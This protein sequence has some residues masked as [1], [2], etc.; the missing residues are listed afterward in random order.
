MLGNPEK[1]RSGK[2]REYS[3]WII[4]CT[5]GTTQQGRYIRLSINAAISTRELTPAVANKLASGRCLIGI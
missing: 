2:R 4:D 3:S 1:Q 5:T